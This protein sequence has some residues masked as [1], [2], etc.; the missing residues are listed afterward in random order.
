M[1]GVRDPLGVRPLVLGKLG[2]AWILASETC[3]LD[4]IGAD[5]VRDV[6]PGEIVIIDARRRA[7]ASSPSSAS[8]SASASSNTSTSRG[9]T[10]SSKATA[11]MRR[12]S[13]SAPSWRARARSTPTSSFRCPIRACRRRSAMPARP[14]CPSSSASSAT[15]MSAAPSSS[16]PIRSAISACKLKHN[17]NRAKL[18]RQARHPGRR[19]DRARHDLDQDRRDGAPAPARAKC[20]C[21][22]R[23]RRPAI[24]ASTASTRP[25]ATSCSPRISTS[26]EMAQLHR[27]RQPRLHL[28]RRA[29]S[30]HGRGAAAIR[31]APQFCDACFT[32]DYPI[33]LD[34]SRRRQGRDPAVAARR[35][36]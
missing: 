33:P 12:A 14:G 6:E 25:S 30:R 32:G 8:A 11:S 31:A 28:D 36:A 22:S 15:T 5:F 34:R 26:Q 20:I 23:A 2:D 17:A 19:F 10:A 35:D 7:A 21:A 29:L 13:A 1:I 4:I 3:A 27:R 18:A 9:P 24:P 16:R